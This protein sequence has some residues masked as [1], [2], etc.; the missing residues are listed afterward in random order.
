MSTRVTADDGKFEPCQ[1]ELDDD[2]AVVTDGTAYIDG[3]VSHANGT[4]VITIKGVR[5]K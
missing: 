5:P 4:V 1:F 3:V 2:F